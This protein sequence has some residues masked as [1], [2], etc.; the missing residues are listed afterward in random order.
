[1]TIVT[2]LFEFSNTAY[3]LVNRGYAEDIGFAFSELTGYTK[4]DILGLNI[5]DI[6]K[7][8]RLNIMIQD[9]DKN[10]TVDNLYMFTKS[11]EAVEVT[12][13]ARKLKDLN[14]SLYVLT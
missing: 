13:S 4:A 3:I 1:M 5:S 7:L 10:K 11:F 9:I 2:S 14:Q 8:L 12:L 6:I